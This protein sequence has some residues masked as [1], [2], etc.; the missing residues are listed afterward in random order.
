[1]SILDSRN[2][3]G[4]IG[5]NKNLSILS[6]SGNISAINSGMYMIDVENEKINKLTKVKN[7]FPRK[8]DRSDIENIRQ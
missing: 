8:H 2:Y 5:K 7:S 6:G 3:I 1:L 4:C